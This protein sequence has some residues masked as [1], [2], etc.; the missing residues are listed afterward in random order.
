MDAGEALVW[1]D[2][3][4]QGLPQDW[5]IRL[6]ADNDRSEPDNRVA[7]WLTV[8]VYDE[9]NDHWRYP[10]LLDV[11][12]RP[13]TNLLV[14]VQALR[15]A[16]EAVPGADIERRAA[17]AATSDSFSVSDY[18]EELNLDYAP[19]GTVCTHCGDAIPAGHE[20][21]PAGGASFCATKDAC[22]AAANLD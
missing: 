19:P 6:V 13:R 8:P 14:A 3:L 20:F 16:Y 17:Y 22:R 21:H 10:D 9:D 15:D 1:L 2:L 18:L 12:S 5:Q 7:L 4:R 11:L